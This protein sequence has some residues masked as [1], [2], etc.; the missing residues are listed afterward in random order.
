MRGLNMARYHN[1][2]AQSTLEYALVI[3]CIVAALIGM[4]HYIKRA[5]Q[6][7]LREAADSIGGQYDPR[8][9]D[10][11]I[12][13]RQSGRTAVEARQVEEGTPKALGARVFGTRTNTTTTNEVTSRTGYETLEEFP[14]GQDALFE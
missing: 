2:K 7:K 12:T 14:E 13:F 4:Q 9:I 3:A 1:K 11:L 6:G 8:H 10:S 5:A